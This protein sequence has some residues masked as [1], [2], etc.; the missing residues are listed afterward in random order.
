MQ[1]LSAAYAVMYVRT[2]MLTAVRM[3]RTAEA[4]TRPFRCVVMLCVYCNRVLSNVYCTYV[5]MYV[6][7]HEGCKEVVL[8][9]PSPACSHTAVPFKWATYVPLVHGVDHA[10]DSK[11]EGEGEEVVCESLVESLNSPFVIR[12]DKGIFEPKEATTFFVTFC[13]Q[14][15]QYSTFG[16]PNDLYAVMCAYHIYIRAYI[17]TYIHT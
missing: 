9:P 1:A 3:F 15:V 17:H 11:E 6:C 8:S 4:A 7:M 12:P 10:S 13:P 5:R 2:Y 16:L 14:K